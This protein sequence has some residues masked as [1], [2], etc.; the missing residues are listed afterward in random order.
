MIILINQ[1]NLI[2]INKSRGGAH[3]RRCAQI[4]N[5]KKNSKK[6]ITKKNIF[7]IYKFQSNILKKIKKKI[8]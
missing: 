5:S 3:M 8:N 4:L 1:S 2:D 7:F 6:K